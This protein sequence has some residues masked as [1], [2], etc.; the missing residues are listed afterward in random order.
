MPASAPI[1][2]LNPFDPQRH[3]PLVETVLLDM[4]GTL[5]DRH[6]DDHFFL[7]SV[8]NHYAQ[9]KNLPLDQARTEVLHAYQQVES[10]LLWYDLDYWSRTLHMDIPLLKREVAHLIAVHP[11]VC[12]F[13]ERVR[14]TGRPLYLVTNAHSASLSL[15]MQRT[16]IGRYFDRILSSHELGLPKEDPNFWPLLQQQLGFNKASTLLAEDSEPVLRSA[17]HYGIAF[18]LHIAAPSSVLAPQFST[19]F[20]SFRDFSQLLPPC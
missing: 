12:P 7:E 11:H 17:A 18:P 1:Q 19:Q 20:S 5:L 6:F 10:T 9:Q 16:P 3:W 15:K 4:D 13:L 14:A 8:P 2:L